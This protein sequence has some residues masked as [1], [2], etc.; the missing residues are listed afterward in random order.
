MK[1]RIHNRKELEHFRKK[2]R[3][4]LTPAEAFLWRYLKAKKLKGRRFNRQHSIKNYIVD[5]YCASEKLVIELDGAVHNTP[6]AKEHDA[7]RTKVINELGYTVIRFENKM[8]FENLE[9]VLSEI[10]EHFKQTP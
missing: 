8:V 4:N 2:L 7:K 9:S 6:Q 10:A 3:K 1:K 5:F